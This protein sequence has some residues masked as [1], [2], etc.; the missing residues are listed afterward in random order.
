VLDPPAFLAVAGGGAQLGL[1]G[2]VGFAAEEAED[3]LGGEGGGGVLEE[4]GG[5]LLEGG[6]GGEDESR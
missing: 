2:R 4:L 6:A 5:D 1:E 3:V